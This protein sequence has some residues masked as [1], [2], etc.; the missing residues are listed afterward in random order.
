ML[1]GA[2]ASM[3]R[4]GQ[5]VERMNGVVGTPD[6]GAGRRDR[7]HFF[8]ER[9][10]QRLAFGPRDILADASMNADAERQMADCAPADVKAVWIFPLLRIEI[11]RAEH[12]Q[13]LAALLELDAGNGCV[14][15]GG[16]AE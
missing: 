7:A 16:A 1:T 6:R 14:R 2:S 11:G 10:E 15:G 4:Q 5:P 13:D 9:R 12:A 3:Q 8:G